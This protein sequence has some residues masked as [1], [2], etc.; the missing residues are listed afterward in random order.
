MGISGNI[1]RENPFNQ[2]L[3][4][5]EFMKVLIL[6][7]GSKNIGFGHITRCISLYQ[8]FQERGIVPE[9]IVNGDESI[10]DL[11]IDKKYKVFNWLEER[12]K[13]FNIIKNADIVIIDSYFTEYDFYKKVSNS[14]KVP[15]YIDDNKRI[16]YPKGIVINGSIHAEDIN[17]PKKKGVDY[18]LGSRYILLRKEF[19]NVPEK[20]VKKNIET[21]MITFGGEDVK[22]MTLKILKL[23]TKNY[24]D[25]HKRVIIGKGFKNIKEIERLKEKRTELMYYLNAEGM[26]KVML[27]S[28][29]AISGGGQTLYELAKVGVPTI[30]VAVADNQLNHAQGWEKS[31]F[32]EYAGCCESE[33]LLKKI[34]KSLNKLLDYDVRIEKIKIGKFLT[35]D[36]GANNI[37]DFLMSYVL[38]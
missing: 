4:N 26:K 9:F 35:K 23:L 34:L 6:T 14:L 8:A 36:D 38:Y 22:N 37:V 11:L 33:K 24:P 31:G 25:L 21:V 16:G 7:E 17:Y 30:A 15:V 19:L 13:I 29:I 20:K 2:F 10:E 1:L 32:I 3:E 27:D 5:L 12:E 18:L 28:D